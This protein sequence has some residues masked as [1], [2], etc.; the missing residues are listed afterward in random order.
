[1]YEYFQLTDEFPKELVHFKRKI[2]GLHKSR[3]STIILTINNAENNNETE[4]NESFRR[5]KQIMMHS[6]R[7]RNNQ[8]ANFEVIGPHSNREV[9]T[10]LALN[11]ANN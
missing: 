6:D 4:L 8:V 9:A 5:T 10:R 1:M 11:E 2:L 7:L 3:K